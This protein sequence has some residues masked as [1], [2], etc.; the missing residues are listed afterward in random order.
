MGLPLLERFQR[1]GRRLALV[2]ALMVTFPEAVSGHAESQEVVTSM[3]G[4]RETMDRLKG[5]VAFLTQAVGERSVRV[6]ANLARARDYISWR[7][8]DAGL[9][10]HLEPYVYGGM[11]VANVVAEVT[12]SKTPSKYYVVGD[13]YDSVAGTVGADDNASA[14]AVLL[15]L[16]RRL[17]ASSHQDGLNLAVTFVSFPLEEP[18]VFSSRFMG[19]RVYASRARREGLAIDGMICLEMVGYRCRE[20]GCQRYP[21]PLMFLG[22]PKEGDFIGLVGNFRS[23]SLTQSLY[24]AFTGNPR[25][26]V[27]KLSV[28]FSGW[29]VPAVRLSD[30]A[31]FWDEG[32]KAV[33]V[34]DSA[35][36]RNP[37]YHTPSDTMDKLD[38][39]FMAE[40]VESLLLFFTSH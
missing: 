9:N 16:A 8:A 34:T 1:M 15:E 27:V 21:F 22:Y 32:F 20:P 29:L 14:V 36:Y 24:R 26:P 19:S 5:H 3:T 33:M 11:E 39:E 40:V 18:P 30:H 13:H 17:K 38:F 7:L 10:L 2:G 35:F 25:L 12:F 4:F 37:H 23:R 31:P 6:P 28:P